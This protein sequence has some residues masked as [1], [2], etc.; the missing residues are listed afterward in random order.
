[1]AA[2]GAAVAEPANQ[3]GR[4]RTM[5]NQEL[6]QYRQHLLSLGA[7]LRG[8]LKG[9][10]ETALSQAGGA[11]ELSNTPLHLADRGTDNFEQEV[12]VTLLQ[13]E[14][15]VL[16]EIAA[17]LDRI[18]AGTFGRCERCGRDIPTGRLQ[19]LPYTPYCISCARRLE[20]QEEAEGAG[21]TWPSLW[22]EGE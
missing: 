22:A 6:H 17:A 14:R 11:A 1:L 16:G 5:N 19:A 3:K 13:N 2:A 21:D 20:D 15:Q 9:L 12:A 18:D 10:T 8:A 7:R 4:R